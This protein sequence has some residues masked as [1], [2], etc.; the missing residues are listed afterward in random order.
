MNVNQLRLRRFFGDGGKVEVISIIIL[1]NFFRKIVRISN[2]ILR[3]S[4]L[5]INF[6]W[7]QSSS[8]VTSGHTSA[9][10][11]ILKVGFSAITESL[12][13]TSLRFN[14]SRDV[15]SKVHTAFLRLLFAL[16]G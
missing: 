11:T 6:A 13:C 5:L 8:I 1:K 14:S 12:A 2:N 15:S 3:S 9:E 7:T 4:S 10:P 16:P